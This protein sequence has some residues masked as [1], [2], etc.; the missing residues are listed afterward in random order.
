MIK[1][2]TSLL[3]ATCL[4]TFTCAANLDSIP[5]PADFKHS[6]Q[7]TDDYPLIQ[8]GY[9]AQS[10][11]EVTAFYHQALGQAEL[12]TGDKLRRT[13]FYTVDSNTVRI[14]LFAHDY[15]TEIAIMI[16]SPSS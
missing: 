8:T 1:I 16:T 2:T 9:V 14:S 3:L 13:L 4:T 10:V 12:I 7:I 5:L 15:T 6:L 11:A